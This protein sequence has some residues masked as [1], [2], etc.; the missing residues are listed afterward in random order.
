MMASE[1][2]LFCGRSKAPFKPGQSISTPSMPAYFM[3]MSWYSM[4]LRSFELY[5]PIIGAYQE[6]T[7]LSALRAFMDQCWPPTWNHGITCT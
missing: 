6:A 7:P 1:L 3:V 5:S 4:T 2:A